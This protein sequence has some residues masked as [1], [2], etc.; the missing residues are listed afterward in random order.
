[1]EGV[2]LVPLLKTPEVALKPAAFSQYHRQ[3]K[4]S[5]DGKRYMGYSM[6]TPRY[7][8][9]QWHTW[10]NDQHVAG[11]QV[12]VELYDNQVD[13]DE[14]VNIAGRPAHAALLEQLAAQLR[15]SRR[16]RRPTP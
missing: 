12:A 15:A 8:Y 4:V 10:D 16:G 2:S 3:P 7:H 5:L 9:V 14:N 11:E 13:P 6:V 1:M